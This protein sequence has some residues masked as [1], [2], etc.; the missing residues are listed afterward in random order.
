MR[1]IGPYVAHKT[2]SA[3]IWPDALAPELHI[4]RA[5]A[6]QDALT[7]TQQPPPTV[8]FP[9][10]QIVPEDSWQVGRSRQIS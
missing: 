5:D 3:S 7:M 6:Q 1:P 4:N 9:L 10:N 8:H 2:D